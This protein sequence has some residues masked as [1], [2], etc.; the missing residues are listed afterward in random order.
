MSEAVVYPP[1]PLRSHPL[2]RTQ[3]APPIPTT[4]LPFLG[5]NPACTAHP[6]DRTQHALR[7]A[8]YAPSLAANAFRTR[9]GT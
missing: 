5:S 4:P 8:R 2:D 3:H 9:C 7:S 6:L 1:L